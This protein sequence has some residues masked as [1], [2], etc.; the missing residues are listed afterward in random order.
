MPL[1]DASFPQLN[2]VDTHCAPVPRDATGTSESSALWQLCSTSA[3]NMCVTR[4]QTQPGVVDTFARDLDDAVRYALKRHATCPPP[5]R[6]TVELP[7]A[8]RRSSR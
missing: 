8:S 2:I 4:P 7:K 5:G 3:C 6:S 1:L